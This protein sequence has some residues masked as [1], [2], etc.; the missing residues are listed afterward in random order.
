MSL[1]FIRLLDRNAVH[2]DPILAVMFAH[3]NRPQGIVAG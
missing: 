1:G 2:D 3:S